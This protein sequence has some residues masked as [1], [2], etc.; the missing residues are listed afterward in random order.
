MQQYTLA[1]VRM[2]GYFRIGAKSYQLIEDE[3]Y[4]GVCV[5]VGTKWIRRIDYRTEVLV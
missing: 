1:D 2:G 5:E 4:Y 3:G